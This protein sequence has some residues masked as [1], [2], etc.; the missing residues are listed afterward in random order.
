M[1][2]RI[3]NG[4]SSLPPTYPSPTFDVVVYTSG[5]FSSHAFVCCSCSCPCPCF[6]YFY[7]LPFHPFHRFVFPLGNIS[8]LFPFVCSLS[9]FPYRKPAAP[10]TGRC[11]RIFL[12]LIFTFRPWYS[13]HVH[14]DPSTHPLSMARDNS[15]AIHH[16]LSSVSLDAY[17]ASTHSPCLLLWQYDI[18]T[19]FSTRLAPFCTPSFTLHR[20]YPISGSALP[21]KTTTSSLFTIRMTEHFP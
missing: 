7:G 14:V 12:L 3:F 8:F 4:P 13:R 15:L 18:A 20:P 17:Y 19:I 16:T 21:H 11:L 6:I 10:F 5:F 1:V 9:F 2:C